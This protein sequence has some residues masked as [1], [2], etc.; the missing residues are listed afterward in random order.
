M[1]M[2]NKSILDADLPFLR[3][4]LIYI[5]S[6][7]HRKMYNNELYLGVSIVLIF[8]LLFWFPIISYLSSYLNLFISLHIFIY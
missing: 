5:N 4:P 7:C 2:I 1:K 6:H 3:I 8:I